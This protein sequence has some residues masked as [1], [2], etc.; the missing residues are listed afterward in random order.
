EIDASFDGDAWFPAWRDD[1]FVEVARDTR[2][3][4]AADEL[5]FAFVRYERRHA[6]VRPT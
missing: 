3:P 5:T 1:E 4:A 2:R 6:V